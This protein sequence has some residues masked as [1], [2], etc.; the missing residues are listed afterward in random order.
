MSP[1][2]VSDVRRREMSANI[3]E[4]KNDAKFGEQLNRSS[5][6]KKLGAN[7]KHDHA[8]EE[9]TNGSR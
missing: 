3:E 9:V 8:E 4:Q 1:R 7:G 5:S 6:R 2:F